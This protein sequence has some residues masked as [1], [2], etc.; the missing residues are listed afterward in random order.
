LEC[1]DKY[2]NGDIQVDNIW[3]NVCNKAHIAI[4]SDLIK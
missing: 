4:D 3:C 1:A 2:D